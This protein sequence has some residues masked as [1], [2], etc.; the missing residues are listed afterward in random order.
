MTHLSRAEVT[1]KEGTVWLFSTHDVF[2]LQSSQ[3]ENQAALEAEQ[4]KFDEQYQTYVALRRRVSS[5]TAQSAELG[6]QNEALVQVN[7]AADTD[8][9]NEFNEIFEGVNMT[10]TNK[11]DYVAEYNA[12]NPESPITLEQAYGKWL[13]EWN[14]YDAMHKE[15]NEWRQSLMTAHRQSSV[16]LLL[17]KDGQPWEEK[18]YNSEDKTSTITRTRLNDEGWWIESR[19]YDRGALKWDSQYSGTREN[20]ARVTNNYSEQTFLKQSEKKE[21]YTDSEWETISQNNITP[22]GVVISVE[23]SEKQRFEFFVEGEN[24]PFIYRDMETN[25]VY[26]P[27]TYDSMWKRGKDET[28]D[29]YDVMLEARRNPDA[30]IDWFAEQIKDDPIQV[31][32]QKVNLFLQAS[33]EYRFDSADPNNPDAFGTKEEHGHFVHHYSEILSDPDRKTEDGLFADDCDGFAPMAEILLARAGVNTYT[34]LTNSEYASHAT[35]VTLFEENDRWQAASLGTYGLDINGR[36]QGL[37]KGRFHHD[38]KKYPLY[39]REGY[40]TQAEA[41]NAVFYKFKLT[42]LEEGEKDSFS[43]N[44]QEEVEQNFQFSD[45]ATVYWTEKRGRTVYNSSATLPISM[46]TASREDV[47]KYLVENEPKVLET[48]RSYSFKPVNN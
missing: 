24:E 46:L 7:T 11:Y 10:F 39:N 38:V 25:Q 45:T 21:R 40:D 16:N 33:F 20:R 27:Y 36:S 22:E 3:Q 6:R 43:E 35:A 1:D 17:D 13:E 34:V 23:D 12:N 4:Q 2:T 30:F 44:S 26:I 29:K 41:L 32:L 47:R 19:G 28:Q 37:N 5:F 8:F 14:R 15:I 18:I 31:K 42:A 9:G 48:E